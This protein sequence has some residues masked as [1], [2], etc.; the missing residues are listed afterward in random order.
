MAYL[1]LFYYQCVAKIHQISMRCTKEVLFVFVSMCISHANP[2]DS[3]V[4]KEKNPQILRCGIQKRECQEQSTTHSKWTLEILHT[5]ASSSET[6]ND[7]TSSNRGKQCMAK[8][9]K[10]LRSEKAFSNVGG[11][12]KDA[13][14]TGKKRTAE[15]PKGTTKDHD[16]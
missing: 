1:W 11:K 3:G 2:Y 12:T 10:K 5:H 7:S 4:S 8:N 9:N 13:R 14:H 16:I 15:S 6:S